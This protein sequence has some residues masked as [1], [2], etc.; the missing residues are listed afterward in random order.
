MGFTSESGRRALQIRAGR[1]SWLARLK[2][3]G[4]EYWIQRGH[5]LTVARLAKA[6]QNR[7]SQRLIDEAPDQSVSGTSVSP[8]RDPENTA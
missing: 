2:R 5:Q 4:P 3:Y 6:Q 7:D 1:A 8:D